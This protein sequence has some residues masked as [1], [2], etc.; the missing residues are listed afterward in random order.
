[1]KLMNFLVGYQFENEMMNDV[2]SRIILKKN[3]GETY[4]EKVDDTTA[5]HRDGVILCRSGNGGRCCCNRADKCC[6]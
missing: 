5:S 2:H 4:E 3:G 1:M 6:G